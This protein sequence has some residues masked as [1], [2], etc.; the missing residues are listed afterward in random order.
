MS[1]PGTP[2]VR[3][4]D[5]ALGYGRHKVLQHLTFTLYEGDFLG[6]VGPN[7]SGKTTIVKALLGILAP[8]EGRIVYERSLHD[9]IRFGYVP[10]RQTLD[11]LFPLSVGEIVR[12]GRYKAAGVLRRLDG[13]DARA[14]DAAVGAVDIRHLMDRRYGELSGG[15]RQRT[16]IARALA[17]G[18]NTLVLD[19]P[20]NGM[21][22]GSEQA[23]LELISRLHDEGE[24]TVVFVSHLLNE[25]ANTVR[26]LALLD[27][28]RFDHGP[29]AE[30]L[31]DGRL[32]ALYRTPVHVERVK[33]AVVV[34]PAARLE[35]GA[36]P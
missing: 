10:Q 34:M 27:E 36:A 2:L 6:L 15:Q 11:E 5:V 22:L 12:M 33:G 14:I 28:G 21:D 18:A 19:E 16:L 25:V 8:L 24:L 13:D 17:A 29:V 4:E 32:S 30:V 1:T 31:T 35:R 20:T 23:I 26:R 9:G 7:G 3:F